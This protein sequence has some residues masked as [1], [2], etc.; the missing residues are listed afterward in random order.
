[1]RLPRR[2][3]KP[4]TRTRLIWML[5]IIGSASWS[6]CTPRLPPSVAGSHCY[7]GV[8]EAPHV[9]AVQAWA[10]TAQAG[11]LLLA[12]ACDDAVTELL[13]NDMRRMVRDP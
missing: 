2:S 9:A 11:D 8:L 4:W 10:P 13:L 3:A 5:L 7:K 1:M 12:R 6:A